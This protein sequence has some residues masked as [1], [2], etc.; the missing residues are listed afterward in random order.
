MGK[1]RTSVIIVTW[2]NEA[3]IEQCINSIIKFESDVQIVVVDNNSSDKTLQ[4]VGMISSKH[5]IVVELHENIGFARANNIGVRHATGDYIL[6]LNPDAYF[7]E[8]GIKKLERQLNDEVGLVG[9]KLLDSHRKLQPS[10]FMFDKPINIV[11]EQFQLGRIFP[12]SLKQN[13]VPYLSKHE[14]KSEADWLVGAFLLLTA[15]DCAQI[16]G[17]STD[18]FLYAEDMDIAFK[19]HM[20][21]KKVVFAP[22]YSIV[23]IGGS[24]ERQDLSSSKKEKM[25]LSRK[26]FS[27]KYG[28]HNMNIFYSSYL[29]KYVVFYFISLFTDRYKEKSVTYK[30]TINILKK[31]RG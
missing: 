6:F 27:E 19:V 17:F 22:D 28:F 8:S 25:F 1:K 16:S 24:S 26:K 23:H 3:D 20:L 14:K 10:M 29:V 2:N 5:I 7:I 9:C 13:F 18:Y 12:E 11:I 4:I 31:I 30:N 21:G 15:E